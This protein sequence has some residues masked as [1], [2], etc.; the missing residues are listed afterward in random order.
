MWPNPQ[1]IVDLVTFTE[2]LHFCVVCYFFGKFCVRTKWMISEHERSSRPEMFCK[3]GVLRNFAKFTVKRLYQ[4][5]FFNKV[6][7]L[8]PKVWNLTKKSPAQV[9]TC[10]FAKFLKTPFFTEHLRWLLLS[11]FCENNAEKLSHLRKVARWKYQQ[12]QIRFT[13]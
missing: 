5:L 13:S 8:R 12:C 2:K 6:A 3:K 9:F 11:N 4:R 7:G 10:E 1:E